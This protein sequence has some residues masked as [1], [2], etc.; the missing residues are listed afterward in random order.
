M[1]VLE[2]VDAVV[3]KGNMDRKKRKTRK[4]REEFILINPRECEIDTTTGKNRK[5]SRNNKHVEAKQHDSAK[6]SKKQSITY[7]K[8]IMK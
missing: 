5:T 7:F 4:R 3:R 1:I 2:E 8:L 6:R